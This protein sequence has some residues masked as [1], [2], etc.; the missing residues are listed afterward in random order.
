MHE[1]P[2]ELIEKRLRELAGR[3]GRYRYA[4]FFSEVSDRDFIVI[5]S[6]N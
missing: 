4:G 3:D 5:T 2:F 1:K 6:Q